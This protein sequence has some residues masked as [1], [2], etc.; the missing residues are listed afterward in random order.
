MSSSADMLDHWWWRTGW[1]V[2]R[3]FYTWHV[4]FDESPSMQSLLDHYSPALDQFP[5]L[6]SVGVSGL[7][8]TV[9]GIGFTD[10][11]S[12]DDAQAIASRA[13]TLVSKI[14]PFELQIG[15]AVVDPETVQTLVSPLEGLEQV[16]D[17]I[18]EAI[19]ETW[20]PE[21]IPERAEGFR[22][23]VTLAYS[24]SSWGSEGIRSAIGDLTPLS[25][26][27]VVNSVSLIDLNRDA[28]RYE[29]T[30][31]ARVTLNG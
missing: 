12:Q 27:V 23:H 3:S 24:N 17:S 31:I 15:P 29:W 28:K 25:V 22:P 21:N 1:K 30:E 16:R 13:S 6:D 2:G 9:Q 5:G 18:R 8:L 14:E 10:Q 20:G 7:H 11:V 19:G 4:T 26:E